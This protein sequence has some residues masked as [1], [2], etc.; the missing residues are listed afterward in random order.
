MTKIYVKQGYIL[1]LITQLGFIVYSTCYR[2]RQLLR[3]HASQAC[4]LCDSSVIT[5][6]SILYLQ[7]VT[8]VLVKTCLSLCMFFFTFDLVRR[9][10][11]SCNWKW[12]ALF[13]H[14]I[15]RGID[16]KIIESGNSKRKLLVYREKQCEKRRIG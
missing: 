12:M 11:S 10:I 7:G 16:I 5:W 9:N 14:N 4:H 15:T 2:Y 13:L 1:T 8:E 6:V 3:L